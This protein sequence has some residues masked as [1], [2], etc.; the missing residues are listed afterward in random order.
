MTNRD[1]HR[2]ITN[3]DG[4]LRRPA[5]TTIIFISSFQSSTIRS[6]QN[7]CGR[8]RDH[9]SACGMRYRNHRCIISLSLSL[10]S[11]IRSCYYV[12]T[13]VHA[14]RL[15]A[16]TEGPRLAYEFDSSRRTERTRR[17]T[18]L[19]HHQDAP[20]KSVSTDDR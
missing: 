17:S 20:W 13:I 16:N 15:A 10:S 9:V 12:P 11:L 6:H 18:A 2:Y 1:R 7:D 8:L 14:P 4:L 5:Y 19:M 3:K